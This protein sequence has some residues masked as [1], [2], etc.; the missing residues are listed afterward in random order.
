MSKQILVFILFSIFC[1]QTV[2][3]AEQKHEDI[4]WHKTGMPE[5]LELARQENRPLFVYWGAVWCPP[6]NSVKSTI[7]KDADF[8]QS[9][10]DYIAVYLDGD[11]EEA[12]KWGEKLKV[13]GYPTL[14]ILSPEGKET[15]R[16]S[17]SNAIP[18]LVSTMNYAKNVW[19]PMS[20]VLLQ[21]LN[22]SQVDTDKIRSLAMY[23]WEQDKEVNDNP[24]DYASRLFQLD[25]KLKTTDN[26]KDRSR[27]F[28]SALS[29]KF[30]SLE[31]EESLAED[32]K[33]TYKNRVLQILDSPE[34]LKANIFDIA[35]GAEDLITQLTNKT[36]DKSNERQVFID[37]FEHVFREFRS[38]KDISLDQYYATFY[39]SISFH[40]NFK[41]KLLE[42]DK[43]QLLEFTQNNLKTITDHKSREAMISEASYLLFK[44]DLKADA[45]TILQEE[46][47]TSN[48]PYYS[49]S[50]LGYF[51]KEDGNNSEALQWYEKAYKSAKGPATKLQW[52]ANYVRNL[53]K[54]NPQDDQAIK[55]NVET[56]LN[57]YTK[58]SDSF[59]GRNYRVLISLKKATGKWVENYDQTDWFK[60]LKSLGLKNCSTSDME[61]YKSACEKYY[62]EFI[63]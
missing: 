27:L 17:P 37:K 50:T 44:F 60:S 7:F 3:C 1:V 62:E 48:S 6:C 40:E 21:A 24:G 26:E 22:A 8:I 38:G 57:N 56:L 35:Y 46:L 59:M 5:A 11:T 15:L 18:D 58:M 10:R 36:S 19:N 51:A 30:K 12:Q 32:L 61:I 43:Q 55:S 34:L 45:K 41:V 9:T 33:K 23:S 47:K 63:L 20:D 54:L 42:Q 53:I 52:Y 29:L 28:M 25:E 31:E 2:H 49:M 14:M 13:M 4:N 16:L 39:P